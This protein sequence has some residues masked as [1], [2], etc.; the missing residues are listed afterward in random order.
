MQESA[1]LVLQRA[2]LVTALLGPLNWE[3][4]PSTLVPLILAVA[5][6]KFG[7][8]IIWSK[9]QLWVWCQMGCLQMKF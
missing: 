7:A 1:A 4:P 6:A 2:A 8:R 5:K 3:T 9:S